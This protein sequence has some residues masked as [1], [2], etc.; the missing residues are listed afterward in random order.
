MALHDV[1][2]TPDE[3]ATLMKINRSSVYRMIKANFQYEEKVAREPILDEDDRVAIIEAA[4]ENRDLTAAEISRDEQL[5]AKGVSASTIE[6][7][8]ND[9]GLKCR[10][11]RVMQSLTDDHKSLRLR[12]ANQ[13]CRWSKAH[14]SRIFYSDESNICLTQNGIQYVRKYD[15]EDWSDIRFRKVKDVR[16]LSINIWM[17]ISYEGVEAIRWMS[18]KSWINGEYYRNSILARYVLHKERLKNGSEHGGMFQQD[19]A[20]GHMATAT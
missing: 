11:K 3:I 9:A 18:S 6:R 15:H 10:R 13:Y 12:L 20:T 4:V 17:M 8:L 16:P 14:L 7:L 19:R 5:N 2:K 1:G